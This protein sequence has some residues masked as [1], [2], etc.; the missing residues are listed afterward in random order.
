MKTDI[1]IIIDWLYYAD[2]YFN[3]CKL[4][5][6]TTNYGTTANSF[7]N[8]SDRVFWVGPVYH[9]LGLATEL[10][11]KAALLLSGSTKDELRKS[12]HDLEVLFTKVSKCRDL[13]N[14]NDTAF[15]AAVAI[16]PP[17]DM[18]ERLEKSGQP[19]AAWY[20]LATHVRSLSSN[21]NIFVGDHEI[22]SDERHRARY[23][24]SDRAYKE[25]CVEV[26]MAG[27]D[28]LLTELYDEFSLRR[29]ETRIR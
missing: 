13:T 18:L 17:D 3:A 6:P 22:T 24:A 8:V 29:T 7:E 9:N 20:L 11:F 27:L 15:S 25:V 28:V 5:H 10:T 1:E 4:L 12:G 16:G 26:V 14:T 19:S 23:A 21:Y 2:S